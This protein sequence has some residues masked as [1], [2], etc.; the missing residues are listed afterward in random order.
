MRAHTT[1]QTITKKVI[2]NQA[3]TKKEIQHLNNLAQNEQ[4]LRITRN[5][6]ISLPCTCLIIILQGETP[7]GMEN[8][9]SS[10][11][12]PVMKMYRYTINESK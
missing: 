7:A 2:S 12:V 9:Y 3:K 8:K 4:I 1:E 10:P 6:Q 5:Q 11:T